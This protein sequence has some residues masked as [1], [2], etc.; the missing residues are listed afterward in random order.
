MNAGRAFGA[1]VIGAAIM[2]AIMVWLRAVGVPLHIELRLAAILGTHLWI[3]GL[4]AYL[5]IG[6]IIGLGY[7]AVFEWVLHQAGVG[8]GLLIGACHTIFAGFVWSQLSGPGRFWENL[9]VPGIAALFLLHFLYGAIV[10]GLYRTE[11]VLEYY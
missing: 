2:S 7:A 11:H 10:G 8:P 6:G 9:G 5:L 3:V 4:A 1:G